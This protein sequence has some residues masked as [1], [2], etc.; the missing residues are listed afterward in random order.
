MTDDWTFG[1]KLA[2]GFAAAVVLVISIAIVS[3]LALSSVVTDKDRL[4]DVNAPLLVDAEAM[5]RPA[6]ARA[7][8]SAPIF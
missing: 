6:S 1:R 5:T 3:I 8:Q 7:A 4:I 2:A